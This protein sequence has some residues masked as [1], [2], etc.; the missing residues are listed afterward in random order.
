MNLAW[1]DGVAGAL[2]ESGLTPEL[3]PRPGYCCVTFAPLGRG[4]DSG[5][6]DA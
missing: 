2:A 5:S 3:A 1:T 6:A 4:D